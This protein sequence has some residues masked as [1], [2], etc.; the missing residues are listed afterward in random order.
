MT[1]HPTPPGGSCEQLTA[2]RP[3]ILAIDDNNDNLLLLNYALEHLDC[4]FVGETSGKSALEIARAQ[5][6]SLILLDLI[7]P[8]MH[9]IELVRSLKQDRRTSAIPIIAVT[10]LANLE[11]EADLLNEGFSE[12]LSKPFMIDEL[13]AMVR[14]YLPTLQRP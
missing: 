9:G 7:M 3:L 1:I 4:E 2:K 12:Y 6:P 11:D 14:R 13:E 5:Q 8:D 10:G